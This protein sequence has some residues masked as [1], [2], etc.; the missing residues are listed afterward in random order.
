M[1][2][3]SRR[4]K[5]IFKKDIYNKKRIGIFVSVEGTTRNDFFENAKS[6]TR[7]FFA[8]INASYKEELF[9]SAI[10]QKGSI[11]RRPDILNEAFKLGKKVTSS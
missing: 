9:C 1:E 5:Y 2:L 4:A 8:T 10:D 3:F 6:I 11:L 7:N